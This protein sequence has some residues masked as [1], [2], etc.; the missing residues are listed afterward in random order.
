MMLHAGG[1]KS[2]RGL[3]SILGNYMKKCFLAYCQ[4]PD[5]ILLVKIKRKLFNIAII[6][7]YATTAQS[8]EYEVDNIYSSIDN[9]KT[10]RKSQEFTVIMGN[11]NAKVVH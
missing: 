10:L 8:T 2:E 3:V 6:F 11:L 5:T 1:K 7:V 9:T 4:I